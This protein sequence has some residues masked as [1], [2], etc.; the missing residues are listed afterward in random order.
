MHLRC[1]LLVLLLH[2]AACSSSSGSDGPCADKNPGDACRLCAA[3]D[4]N[5]IETMQVK[6]CSPT[7]VCGASYACPEDGTINCMPVVPEARKNLCSG[8]YSTWIHQ[9]CPGVKFAQ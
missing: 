1:L 6:T 9:H 5:C 2:V 3:D 8:A 7:G 4:P